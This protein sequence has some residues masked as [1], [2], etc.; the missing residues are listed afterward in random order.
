MAFCLF[1]AVTG[2]PCPGCGITRGVIEI[3]RGNFRKAWRL[4][5][6]SFAVVLFFGAMAASASCD[7]PERAARIR[8]AADRMLAANLLM[9]WLVRARRTGSQPVKAG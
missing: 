6:G 7:S 3:A 2:V 4:N 1:R 5:P 8:L 9:I